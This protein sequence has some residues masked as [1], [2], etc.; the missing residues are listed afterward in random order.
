MVSDQS[1]LHIG[2]LWHSFESEN[3]GMGALTIGNCQLIGDAVAKL[4]RRPVFHII[5][6]SGR[7]DYRF[8]TG[9]EN[10]FAKVGYKDL[11]TPGS[12]LHRSIDLCELFF[13]IGAGDSFSDIYGWRRFGLIL[14]SKWF[15]AKRGPLVM[16]PQT[17]GP[18]A[19]R[20]S[21]IAATAIMKKVRTVYAR[22]EQ[23]F[24]VLREMGLEDRARLT[25]DVAFAL[26]YERP[27]DKGARDLT[28]QVRVG[29]N[30]SALLYRRDIAHGDRIAMTVDY[31]RLI[32]GVI[33]RLAGDPRVELHLVPHV[34]AIGMEHEDDYAVAQTLKAQFPALVL[35]ARFAGPAAAKSYVANLDFLI[36]SRMHAT[37]AALSS[38]TAVLPFGYSR[39]FSGLFGSLGYPAVGDLTAQD[40]TALLAMLDAAMAD[41]PGLTAAATAANAEA[42]TRL[43]SYRTFLDELF[44]ELVPA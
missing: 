13:D 4:G 7:M 8:E 18:F 9:F 22:D 38:N 31:P 6:A 5:G 2:L 21:R 44:A 41:L 11:A 14:A 35:P 20:R 1:A 32:N 15:A 28:G 27:D 33:R 10:D 37:V 3:L 26:P 36:G 40:E 39:K 19:T 43:K 12:S 42:Q 29:L 24:S 25:T 17:I 16:S 30:V 34:L 23:S